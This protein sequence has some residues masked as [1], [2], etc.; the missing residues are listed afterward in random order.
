MFLVKYNCVF[1]INNLKLHVDNFYI[2]VMFII[3]GFMGLN[4]M[5]LPMQSDFMQ[6]IKALLSVH[7]IILRSFYEKTL[8]ERSLEI[9]SRNKY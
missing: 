6:I 9:I 4:G 8:S 2:V 7:L 1:T 5:E 3:N